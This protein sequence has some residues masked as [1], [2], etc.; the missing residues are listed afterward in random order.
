VIRHAKIFVPFFGLLALLWPITAAAKAPHHSDFRPQPSPSRITSS[1]DP[2]QS[3][4]EQKGKFRDLVAGKEV[5][6]EEFEISSSAAGWLARGNATVKSAN[7]P[8][9]RITSQLQLAAGGA[10]IHYEWSTITGAKKA[11][12]SVDFSGGTATIHLQVNGSQ[13]YTQ[14]FFFKSPNIVILDDNLYYQYAILAE[15]YDW[16][17]KG[18]QTFPV[19]I[20]QEMTPGSITAEALDPE[21]VNG[22]NLDRLRVRSQDLE[23]ILY[24]DGNRLE[25]ISVPTANAEIIRQ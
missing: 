17:K 3:L 4:R 5:G 19:L 20:P 10:P 8:E 7:G 22:K 1:I 6:S 15:L 2:A 14:Q 23:I 24:L 21:N 25:K 18:L 11:A 16:S 13:P 12:A 9:T